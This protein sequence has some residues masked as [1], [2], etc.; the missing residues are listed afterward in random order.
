MRRVCLAFLLSVGLT[1]SVSAQ[2]WC[3]SPP[4]IHPTAAQH[5]TFT[6][7]F[8]SDWTDSERSC[9]RQAFRAWE[10]AL[11]SQDI[12]FVEGVFAPNIT[13]T[14]QYLPG[15]LAGALTAPHYEYGAVVGFGIVVTNDRMKISSCEGYYKVILHEVGHGLGLGHTNGM[16]GSSIMNMLGG[17]NDIQGNLPS[18]PT[19]CDV[20][21][22]KQ[23]SNLSFR[24]F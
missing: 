8:M 22:M 12:H 1:V 13:I 19:P 17:P 18:Y 16:N 7:Q 15:D 10:L 9:I 4:L 6:Y 2:P 3:L 11:T 14:R 20:H 23:N 21:P 24:R 5:T